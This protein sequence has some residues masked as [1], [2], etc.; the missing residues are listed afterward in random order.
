[1][2]PLLHLHP[3]G[4]PPR[5]GGHRTGGRYDAAIRRYAGA[6]GFEVEIVQSNT[7]GVVIDRLF[8]AHDEP[9]IAGGIINPDGFTRG[10]PALVGAIGRVRCWRWKGESSRPK[11]ALSS[12]ARSCRCARPKRS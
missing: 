2:V 4:G 10:Y 9:H 7:E 1:M 3:S 8:A 11:W 6:H 5:G 12:R